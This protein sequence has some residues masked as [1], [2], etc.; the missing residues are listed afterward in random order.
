MESSKIDTIIQQLN[1]LLSENHSLHSISYQFDKVAEIIRELDLKIII[2]ESRQYY[3]NA[4]L[5]LLHQ[6]Q[7][8]ATDFGEALYYYKKEK[9]ILERK[10]RQEDA[11][12][13]SEPSFFVW[14]NN[15]L[16]GYLGSKKNERLIQLLIEGYNLRTQ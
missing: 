8:N 7:N 15:C 5:D 2:I 16:I 4:E 6:K 11:V 9:E 14:R 1:N 13:R 10:Q 12:L 3:L